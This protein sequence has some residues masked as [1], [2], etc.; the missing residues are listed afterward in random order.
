MSSYNA[1]PQLNHSNEG[2]IFAVIFLLSI[3]YSL[4]QVYCYVG[5][6]VFMAVMKKAVFWDVTQYGC[7][8][9]R[10]SVRSCHLQQQQHKQ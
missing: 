10:H 9:K 7:C 1:Q 6:K 2:L 8:N 5:V 3:L 4:E